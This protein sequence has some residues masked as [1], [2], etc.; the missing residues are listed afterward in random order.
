VGWHLTT[1][2]PPLPAAAGEETDA[3]VAKLDG[4][5]G[6]RLWGWQGGSAGNDYANAVAL[7]PIG[8]VYACGSA[9]QGM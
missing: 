1:P 2:P 6:T 4:A 7:D 9:P 3:F 5:N 8:D